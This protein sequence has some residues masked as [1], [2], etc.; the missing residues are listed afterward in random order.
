MMLFV[1]SIHFILVIFIILLLLF[2]CFFNLKI[3]KKGV[4]YKKY[5][6]KVLSYG[7]QN[8]EQYTTGINFA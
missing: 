4:K 8:D 5:G 1:S 2:C 7:K 3:A 6:E